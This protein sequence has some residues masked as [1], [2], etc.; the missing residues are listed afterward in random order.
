V[1]EAAIVLLLVVPAAVPAGMA[2]AAGTLLVLAAAIGRRLRTGSDVRCRC[3]GAG[4]APL[5]RA[6]LVRNLVLAGFATTGLVANALGSGD[7]DN[8]AAVVSA[9]AGGLFCAL[10]VIRFDDL[11]SLFVTS[12]RT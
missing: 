9:V 2:L 12:P 1:C 3:F 4:T 8:A 6:H 7:V 5:G 11:L 10:F